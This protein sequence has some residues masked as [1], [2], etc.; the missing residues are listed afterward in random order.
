MKTT[1]DQ[2]DLVLARK[3]FDHFTRDGLTLAREIIAMENRLSLLPEDVYPG[4]ALTNIPDSPGNNGNLPQ[5]ESPHSFPCT[6]IHL[7][8]IGLEDSPANAH[9]DLSEPFQL[10]EGD[11]LPF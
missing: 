6:D 4:K 3:V 7:Q 1:I 9:M 11:D 5:S 8:D 2:A 10:S